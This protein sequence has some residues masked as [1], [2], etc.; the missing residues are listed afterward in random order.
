MGLLRRPLFSCGAAVEYSGHGAV[1]CCG[2]EESVMM[3]MTQR[4]YFF[5][6]L[7]VRYRGSFNRAIPKRGYE[8]ATVI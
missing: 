4:G 1:V 7:R 3:K 8:F 6:H 2:K 5:T